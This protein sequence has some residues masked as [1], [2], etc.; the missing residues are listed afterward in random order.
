[1][2]D[3]ADATMFA[4]TALVWM[5]IPFLLFPIA[6]Q[7]VSTSVTGILNGGLPVV[8][9]VVTALFTS[10]VP[11]LVRIVAVSIGAVGIAMISLA[12]VSGDAGADGRGVALLLVALLSYA[13]A[14]NISR[15]LQA[16]YATMPMMLW[17]AVFGTAW[18]MP[19]GLAGAYPTATSRGLPSVCWWRSAPWVRAWRSPSTGCCC[20]EPVRCGG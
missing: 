13:V 9:T 2:I 4:V 7:T 11:S 17:V 3:R 6:E 14:S 19:L 16:K 20:N 5:S 8:N 10:T 12:S 15:P 18:S 1:M